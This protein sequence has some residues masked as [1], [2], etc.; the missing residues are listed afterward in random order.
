[1]NKLILFIAL[2]IFQSCTLVCAASY[3]LQ[4]K[5]GN[6]LKT[7][8]YWEEGNEI[9]FYFYGGIVGVPK[10][11]VIG[12]KS[13]NASYKEN[14]DVI[15]T[16]TTVKDQKIEGN[17]KNQT[18]N[19]GTKISKDSE[20]SGAIDPNYYREQKAVLK[21]KLEEALERNREAT[22]RKDQE[23]KD[24]TRMEIREYTKKIYNLEAELKEK[25]K[26]VIPDWWKE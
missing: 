17:R 18:D 14:M 20:K 5:N 21:D 8:H 3:Q 19:K 11:N 13:Y 1:M 10:G 6:E 26:G 2:I 16:E 12:I 4:L 7:S 15:P 9:K 24:A 22:L 25:N 23:A